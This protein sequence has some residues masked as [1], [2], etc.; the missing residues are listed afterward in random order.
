MF[1]KIWILYEDLKPLWRFEVFLKAWN[2]Y[3][4]LEP[5]HNMFKT[6]IK[7]WNRYK[8]LKP[9]LRFLKAVITEKYT[10]YGIRYT[11]CDLLSATD[12]IQVM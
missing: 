8:D 5:L 3:E 4:D 2:L 10:V 12:D 7:I 11:L 1:T 9:L 6:V